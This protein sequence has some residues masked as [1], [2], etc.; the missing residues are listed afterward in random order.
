MAYYREELRRHHVLSTAEAH[1]MPAGAVINVAGLAIRPHRPPTRSGRTV[2]FFSLE[3]EHGMLDITTFEDVYQ[4][5]GKVIYRRDAPAP[6]ERIIRDN[7]A[8]GQSP[9]ALLSRKR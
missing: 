2:V 5:Y 8:R 1:A 4:R 7:T 3:D 6:S 9:G